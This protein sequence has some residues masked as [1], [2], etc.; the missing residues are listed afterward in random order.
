MEGQH[1]IGNRN[2]IS[3]RVAV[4]CNHFWCDSSL[5]DK[6]KFP[7]S[8]L[9]SGKDARKGYLSNCNSA[10]PEFCRRRSKCFSNNN[11]VLQSARNGYLNVDMGLYI[12][13][14]TVPFNS[15][16]DDEWGK[17]I[18]CGQNQNNGPEQWRYLDCPLNDDVDEET[19]KM[20]HTIIDEFAEDNQ[21][22]VNQFAEVFVKMLENGYDREQLKSSTIDW[23][24]LNFN[25]KK[26]LDS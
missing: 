14:E 12:N 17:P 7:L 11:K 9:D 1:C 18:P 22:W 3:Q 13:F 16:K 6:E 20:M 4:D 19:N 15:G 21:E 26:Y 8:P 25:W 10:T 5:A 23:Q 24:N 2:T